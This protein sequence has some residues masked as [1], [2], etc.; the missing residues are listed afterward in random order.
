MSPDSPAQSPSLDD[1]T[2]NPSSPSFLQR[3][4]EAMPPVSI[5]LLTAIFIFAGWFTLFGPVNVLAWR[6]GTFPH[7]EGDRPHY[8]QALK[9]IAR[10]QYEEQP[11]PEIYFGQA[12]G[13]DSEEIRKAIPKVGANPDSDADPEENAEFAAAA[14]DRVAGITGDSATGGNDRAGESAEGLNPKLDAFGNEVDCSGSWTAPFLSFLLA[15]AGVPL[16]EASDSTQAGSTASSASANPWLVTD[17]EQLMQ[18][19]QDHDAFMTDEEF[20]P[21]VGDIIFY[22][23][24]AGLGVHA[25]MVVG[26]QGDWVTIGGDELG[27][28]G[29]ASMTVRNRGGIVGYGATGLFENSPLQAK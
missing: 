11:S 10:Y 5:L 26:V 29:L 2:E 8:Q 25:N 24:P 16:Y 28:V 4:R 3:V 6:G 27:K 1:G 18:A 23:Y 12:C 22:R 20:S 19:Y 17:V 9:D 21:Q 13:A 15:S 14:A 7:T